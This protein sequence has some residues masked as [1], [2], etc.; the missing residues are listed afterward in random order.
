MLA[1]HTKRSEYMCVYLY[2]PVFLQGEGEEANQEPCNPR[3]NK[4]TAGLYSLLCPLSPAH[5]RP[6]PRSAYPSWT[7]CFGSLQGRTP[8]TDLG[9]THYTGGVLPSAAP[10]EWRCLHCPQAYCMGGDSASSSR[11]VYYSSL[12]FSRRNAYSPTVSSPFILFPAPPM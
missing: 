8:A 12:S 5:T 10:A 9:A 4:S 3:L 1:I 2:P 7:V 6:A 11:C